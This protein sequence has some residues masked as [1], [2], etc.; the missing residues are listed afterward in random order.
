MSSDSDLAAFCRR[1]PKVELHAH[2]NGSISRDSIKELLGRLPSDSPLHAE[3]AEF[4]VQCTMNSLEVFFPLFKFI[5]QLSNSFDNVRYFTR[6]V[7]RE[8][9]ADGCHYLELRSTP[10]S[11]PDTD[12]TT[13]QT[14]VDA[15]IAG[16]R[17]AIDSFDPSLHPNLI[18]VRLILSLDR[19]HS[20]Q[21]CMETVDLAIA[22]KD[23]G[24]VGV[25]LCGDPN[26]GDFEALVPAFHKARANGLKITL[27]LAE[28]AGLDAETQ[29]MIQ[30]LPD[31][32]GHGTYLDGAIK[33]HVMNQTVPIEMCVSSNL[34]TK[35]V[36]SIDDHHFSG[37]FFEGHPCVLCTDDKGVFECSLSGEYELVA[38]HFGFSKQDIFKLARGAIEHIFADQQ[39]KHK[40]RQRMD[41][42]QLAEGL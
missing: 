42:F 24:V 12:L 17:D 37:F 31:R 13:K 16:I 11:H 21:A 33:D 10:R 6:N 20:L 34:V 32:I 38:R 14:Y 30:F 39:M 41:I 7:V 4:E 9:A 8:F 35:T 25:D 26:C 36:Q 18:Q 2:L 40:L 28:V 3:F 5:Y 27:H 1:L 29:T 19:R 22:Y 15:M 23:K